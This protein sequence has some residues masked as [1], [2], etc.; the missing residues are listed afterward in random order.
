LRTA[1]DI[2]MRWCPIFQNWW[3]LTLGPIARD[4]PLPERDTLNRKPEI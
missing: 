4:A 1:S 3:R 2:Q